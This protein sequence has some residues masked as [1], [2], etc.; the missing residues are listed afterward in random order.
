MVLERSGGEFVVE[1]TSDATVLLLGGEPIDELVVGHAPF[2][3]NTAA[4]IS[5]AIED[6]N[7]S[8]FGGLSICSAR[9]TEI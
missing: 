5:Q 9:A 2:V 7:R 1:A 4:E 3:M 8:R 6:D